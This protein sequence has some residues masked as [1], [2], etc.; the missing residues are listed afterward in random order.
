MGGEG[1]SC[2]LTLRTCKDEVLLD[3]RPLFNTEIGHKKTEP[4]KTSAEQYLRCFEK[5]C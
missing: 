4:A 3:V 2:C 1:Q 5:S